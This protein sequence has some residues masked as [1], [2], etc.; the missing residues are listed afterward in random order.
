[1]PQIYDTKG[2]SKKIRHK[3]N[4]KSKTMKMKVGGLKPSQNEINRVI[5][6][7]VVKEIQRS[8]KQPHIVVSKDGYVVDGHHRWAAYKKMNPTKKIR[9][10]KMDAPI[11]D[12]LGIAIATEKRR[13]AF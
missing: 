5:V 13:D 2:F 11:H 12:A 4:V 7:K 3:F 10:L 9:V 1:M 8:K 6:D